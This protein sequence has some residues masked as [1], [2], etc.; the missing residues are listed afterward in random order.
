[1]F[2][3]L[4]AFLK[5]MNL[6]EERSELKT[7]R[8]RIR[9]ISQEKLKY[10]IRLQGRRVAPSIRNR[11]VCNLKQNLQARFDVV[12]SGTESTAQQLGSLKSALHTAA[13]FQKAPSKTARGVFAQQARE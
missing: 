12:R 3:I 6:M 9:F 11:A 13:D 1:M 4:L 8:T 5:A 10:E 7:D 2:N